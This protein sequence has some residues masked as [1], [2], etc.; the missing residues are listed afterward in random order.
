MASMPPP[1][2]CRTGHPPRSTIPR[3]RRA[4]RQSSATALSVASMPLPISRRTRQPVRS[5]RV[6][7]LAM[8]ASGDDATARN[9]GKHSRSERVRNRW[10][11]SLTEI[12]AV[13]LLGPCSIVCSTKQTNS[14]APRTTQPKACRRSRRRR[15]SPTG[16][17]KHV[18]CRPHRLRA[19]HR[20]PRTAERTCTRAG[21]AFTRR[22]RPAEGE[23]ARPACP[24]G[25][26]G[27]RR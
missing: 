10:Q 14:V 20:P 17:Q 15:A 19:R 3:N 5:P 16:R 4:Q 18:H 22:Q 25:A 13:R 8:S 2:S 9:R 12:H 26:K 6:R 21:R 27:G 7:H 23:P 24:E 11:C 1:T